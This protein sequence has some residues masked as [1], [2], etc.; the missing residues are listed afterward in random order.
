MDRILER[1]IGKFFLFWK[2]VKIKDL[3]FELLSNIDRPGRPLWLDW[4]DQRT[5]DPNI[6]NETMKVGQLYDGW[7]LSFKALGAHTI[8]GML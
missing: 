1:Q 3:S 6:V 8:V 4:N 2:K 7:L 5:I